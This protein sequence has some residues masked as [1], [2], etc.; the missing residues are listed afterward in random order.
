MVESAG[1]YARGWRIVD[2]Y[3]DGTRLRLRSQVLA[4][5]DPAD[6]VDPLPDWIDRE[7]TRDE[8]FTGDALARS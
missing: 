3:L 6:L 4:E 8:A 2:R 1:T 7:V 5:V